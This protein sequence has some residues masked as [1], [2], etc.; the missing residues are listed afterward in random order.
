M[1]QRKTASTVG[2]GEDLA[3]EPDELVLKKTEERRLWARTLK[4]YPEGMLKESHRSSLEALIKLQA[5][6]N[7]EPLTPQALSHLIGLMKQ[8]DQMLV[9]GAAQDQRYKDR[10]KRRDSSILDFRLGGNERQ[11]DLKGIPSPRDLDVIV[12]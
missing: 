4:A 5:L 8:F 2:V 3:P 12:R 6:N 10:L 9:G 1:N 11:E 7:E